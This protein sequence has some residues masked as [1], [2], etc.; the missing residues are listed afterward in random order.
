MEIIVLVPTC[1]TGDNL[2]IFCV[3]FISKCR[4][5][6]LK[7]EWPE[8]FNNYRVREIK[9]C[10]QYGSAECKKAWKLLNDRRFSK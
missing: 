8:Q 2:E 5:G 7:A 3:V 1:K 6:K 9:D 10:S 4:K